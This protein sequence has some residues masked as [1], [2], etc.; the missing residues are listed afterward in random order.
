MGVFFVGHPGQSSFEYLNVDCCGILSEGSYMQEETRPTGRR[1]R[2]P[3]V[4]RS[5]VCRSRL[6][7]GT[8]GGSRSRAAP[9]ATIDHRHSLSYQIILPLSKEP[10]CRNPVTS[11]GPHWHLKFPIAISS[12][13]LGQNMCQPPLPLPLSPYSRYTGILTFG[14]TNLWQYKINLERKSPT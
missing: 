2:K 12:H 4:V 3:E 10:R 6:R 11:T 8:Y 5:S 13:P 9:A 14:H 1:L 7:S